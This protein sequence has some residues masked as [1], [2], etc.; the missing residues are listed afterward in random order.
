[1]YVLTFP[2]TRNFTLNFTTFYK[3]KLKSMTWY[4][5][6][7]KSRFIYK[8]SLL[9]EFSK[10]FDVPNAYWKNLN[11]FQ[12]FISN[13]LNSVLVLTKCIVPYIGCWVKNIIWL[14]ISKGCVYSKNR[15]II[16]IE[17]TLIP[18]ICVCVCVFKKNKVLIVRRFSLMNLS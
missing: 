16:N 17:Y 2:K 6:K 13:V 18:Y 11:S 12:D 9:V 4:Y 5:N 15:F 14:V 10:R 1:M 7:L 8:I 3:L